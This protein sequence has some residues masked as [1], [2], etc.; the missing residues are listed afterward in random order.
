MSASTSNPPPT[1]PSGSLP[2]ASIDDIRYLVVFAKVAESGS[3]ASAA[4]VLGLSTAT[5][6]QHVSRL[7]ARLG[8]ALLYRNT[9]S[10]SL[11]VDGARLLET[12]QSMLALYESGLLGFRQR[13]YAGSQLRIA[14]PAV[15]LRS[16]LLPALASCMR[17]HPEVRFHLQSADTRNDLI[18]ENIDFA[19]RIGQLADS[20]LKARP[21]FTLQRWVVAAPSLFGGA[22]PP[23]NPEQLSTLP[24]IGLSM[25]AHERRFVHA[26]GEV[27]SFRYT[28]RIQVDSVELAYQLSKQGLGLAAPPDFLVQTDASHEAVCRLLPEW[29]L[30]PLSVHAL[31]PANL[32]KRSLAYAVIEAVAAKLAASDSY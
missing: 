28:P 8:A 29:S 31:W 32:S 23:S 18:G 26:S 17:A 15:L 30:E 24:W 11:T 2:A 19:F 21:I 25:R 5:T 14:L 12:A 16:P 13:S 7:E 10:L 22:E 1:P 3:F 20:G 9:R 4:R 6:S 27:C